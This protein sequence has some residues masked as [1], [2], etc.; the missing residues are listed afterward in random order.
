MEHDDD[1]TVRRDFSWPA[2][3]LPGLALTALLIGS[4]GAQQAGDERPAGRTVV[5]LE[6]S[7]R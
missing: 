2:A 3:L 7:S 5:E 6:V 4:V 1:M